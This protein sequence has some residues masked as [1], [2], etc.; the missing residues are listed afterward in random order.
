MPTPILSRAAALLLVTSS[1]PVAAGC[2]GHTKVPAPLPGPG[3]D[4]DGAAGPARDGGAA[5]LDGS[6]PDLPVTTPASGPIA[7]W[8]ARTIGAPGMAASEVRSGTNLMVIRA[9]GAAV[10]GTADSF[11]FVSQKVR[12]DFDLVA[13]V[14]S[15]QMV[16]PDTK[17]GLMAR[18]GDGEAGAANVFLAV[19]ADPMRGGLLQARAAPDGPTTTGAPDAG[20]RAGQWLRLVRQG[21]SFTALRSAARLVWTKV[22]SH[23][24]DLPPELTVGIAVSA[25]SA[26]ATT[27]AEIDGLRLH[28]FENQ[29]ATREWAL[30]EMGAIGASALWNGANLTFTGMGDGPSLLTDS[31]AFAH[32]SASGNQS[33]T[34]RVAAFTHADPYA[35][36]A[37]MVR[38]GPPVAFSRT[39]PSVILS[40][41]AG[42]GVHFQSRAFNNLMATVAP[43]KAGVKAPVWLRLERVE[44]P[45]P[46]GSRFTGSYSTDGVTW[47]VAGSAAFALPEPYLIGVM[48][49]SNG[50]TTPAVATLTDLSLGAA[51]PPPPPPPPM[52]AARPDSARPDAGGGG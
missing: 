14:R 1:L 37:L 4:L 24:L 45:G 7:P 41:T 31:G 19:L 2:G 42:M 38:E 49:N 46:A 34:V 5:R 22:G 33:L 6:R 44:N 35:R 36:V 51:N 11:E 15:L 8:T 20:V 25:R 13:R 26:T 32:R 48:A 10:G 52:D 12:G 9:G 30:E 18:A 39:Q 21:R 29:P 43:V 40:V 50:T 16:D 23:D 47:T 28:G 17:V 27:T 3:D